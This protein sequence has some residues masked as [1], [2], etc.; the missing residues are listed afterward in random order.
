MRRFGGFSMTSS[1]L[2]SCFGI[3]VWDLL[4]AGRNVAFVFLLAR[5]NGVSAGSSLLLLRT[6]RFVLVRGD[7]QVPGEAGYPVV[8]S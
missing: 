5:T 3:V 7:V 4:H 8:L 6:R 1:G 2:R